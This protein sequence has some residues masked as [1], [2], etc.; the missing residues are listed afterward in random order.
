MPIATVVPASDRLPVPPTTTGPILVAC[1]GEP[2]SVE[3]L[4]TAA[5]VA[6]RAVGGAVQVVGVCEPTP[7]IAAGAEVVVAP[8]EFETLRQETLLDDIR[9]V[10]SSSAEGDPQWPVDV[11]IGAPARTLAAMA[12]DRHAGML[13]MG[14]GRHNPVDRL[15]GA[16]TTLAT[17]RESSVPVLAVGAHFP[18]EPRHAVVGMD[19]GAASLEAA[20]LAMQFVGARGHVTLVHVRP[21]FEHPSA[22]WQDWD[23]EYGRTL[24]PLF[25]RI[26]TTL[27]PPAT[28]TLDTSVVRGEPAPSLL[29]VA[30]QA[31]ADFVALGT[32]H[33]TLVE[34]LMVGSVAT[35]VLRTARC[36]VLAVPKG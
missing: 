22:D 2:A 29:A 26:R 36:P 28:L 1:D 9:R 18:S 3:A 19:F 34:R 14:I 10:V 4:F 23:L 33:H 6:Q 15:F 27:A 21:R 5:R 31:H 25:D 12:R 24:P 16:E 35:R 11:V 7:A 17:V 30:Q 8:Q 13:V 20:R 32:Q